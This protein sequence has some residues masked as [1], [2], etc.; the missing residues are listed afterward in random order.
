MGHTVRQAFENAKRSVSFQ[1]SP[2]GAPCCCAHVHTCVPCGKCGLPTCCDKHPDIACHVPTKCCAPTVSHD[3]SMKFRLL[4]ED[5]EHEEAIFP[6]ASLAEGAW[7]NLSERPVPSNIP[8]M[9]G[10]FFQV[11]L[12]TYV[13]MYVCVFMHMR[14]CYSLTPGAAP[15]HSQPGQRTARQK[16]STHDALRPTGHRQVLSGSQR[17]L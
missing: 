4:P 12:S 8:E 14:T 3:E 15:S 10:M 7:K 2:S 6:Q 5:E 17:G 11:C 16:V 9:R 13:C 1:A